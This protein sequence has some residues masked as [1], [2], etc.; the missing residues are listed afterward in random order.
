MLRQLLADWGLRWEQRFDRMAV[1]V[2][3]L[4]AKRSGR[5]QDAAFKRQL[6]KAGFTVRFA[7]SPR[8]LDAHRAIVGENVALI[9]SI[10]RQFHRGVEKLVTEAATVGGA[11]RELS[12]VIRKRYGIT[13]RRAAIIA[14]DQS[15]KSHAVFES[16]RR[17]DLGITEAEWMHSHA[18]KVPRPEHVRWGRERRRFDV[19]KGLWSEVDQEWQLPG[20]AINCRCGSRAIIPDSFVR[21]SE[22]AAARRGKAQDEQARNDRRRRHPRSDH[23]SQAR[24]ETNGA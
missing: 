4:F 8:M 7:P 5:Y 22:R 14:R 12:K 23:A 11:Q 3:R 1:N 19:T 20:T 17:T 16:A 18:G 21:A 2:A 13:Y 9:R 24:R 6:R 15:A 10:P